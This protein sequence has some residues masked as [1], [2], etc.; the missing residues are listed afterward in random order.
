MKKLINWYKTY[1]SKEY[2]N[3][4]LEILQLFICNHLFRGIVF[5]ALAI[6]TGLALGTFNIDFIL[7]R[8]LFASSVIYF[9]IFFIILMIYAILGMIEDRKSKKPSNKK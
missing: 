2:K 9:I 4:F 8:I 5:F 7:F 3:I 6:S 1:K